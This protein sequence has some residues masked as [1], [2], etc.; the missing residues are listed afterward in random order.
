MPAEA[1]AMPRAALVLGLG[2]LIPFV[3][4][5]GLSAFASPAMAAQ[6]EAWLVIYAVTILSFLG[7][8]RWGLACAGMG[9]GPSM[10]SLTLS[11]LPPLWA[12]FVLISGLDDLWMLA[13]GLVVWFGADL[14]LSRQ[15]GTPDWWLR[16]RLPL[17]VVGTMSLMVAALT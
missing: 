7:G 14:L 9:P 1:N 16:L 15:G 6:V 2:G 11:V 4:L 12:W 17:T 10:V 5:A 13:L 8:T 3:G